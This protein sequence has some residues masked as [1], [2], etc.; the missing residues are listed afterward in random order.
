MEFFEKAFRI[1]ADR[2]IGAN[3][4]LLLVGQFDYLPYTDH[5]NPCFHQKIKTE[6]TIVFSFQKAQA[7]KLY[8]FLEKCNIFA[9]QYC[10]ARLFYFWK[11][12]LNVHRIHP[13]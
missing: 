1:G 9:K 12:N 13:I 2:F 11:N 3:P 4:G 7:H 10:S 5:F 6:P 8:N